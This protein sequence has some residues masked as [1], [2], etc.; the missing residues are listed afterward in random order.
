VSVSI[1]RPNPILP[2]GPLARYLAHPGAETARLLHHLGALAAHLGVTA[3]GREVELPSRQPPWSPAP[4]RLACLLH[5]A[6]L[7]ELAQVKRAG[8]RRLTDQLPCLGGGEHVVEAERL[9]QCQ[10]NRMR[11]RP[12]LPRVRYVPTFGF[13]L[14]RDWRYRRGRRR[15]LGWG[16]RRRHLDGPGPVGRSG[17]VGGLAH[18]RGSDEEMTGIRVSDGQER[19][20]VPASTHQ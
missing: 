1:P 19:R 5:K 16:G 3:G 8:R 10:S 6:V 4:W 11:H 18:R 13:H 2:S 15:R 7:G 12:E 17:A 14:G 20:A 9:E